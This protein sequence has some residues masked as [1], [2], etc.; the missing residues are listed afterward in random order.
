MTTLTLY[1]RRDCHLC[2][3]MKAVVR[4]VGRTMPLALE[5]MDIDRDPALA[6]RYGRAIPVLVAGGREIARHRVTADR[7]RAVL[8]TRT[9]GHHGT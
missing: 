3:E 5:E 9:A 8:D 2:E 4:E 1:T 7:L 6:R